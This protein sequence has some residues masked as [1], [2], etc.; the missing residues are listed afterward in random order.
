MDPVQGTGILLHHITP[1]LNM[2]QEV[3]NMVNTEG[4]VAVEAVTD[5]LGIEVAILHQKSMKD[6]LH[7][8]EVLFYS[9]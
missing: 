8:N 9:K 2:V 1:L 6:T 5:G 3:L 4:V 7:L